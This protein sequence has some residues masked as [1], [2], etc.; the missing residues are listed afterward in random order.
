ME[1]DRR[2]VST[3]PL[4]QETWNSKLVASRFV[5]DA[6]FF[7]VKS[8]AIIL[9]PRTER[10]HNLT[11][12]PISFSVLRLSTESEFYPE[13]LDRFVNSCNIS[14]GFKF[15]RVTIVSYVVPWFSIFFFFVRSFTYP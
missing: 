14:S 4:R 8:V 2:F 9:L 15:S 12:N 7:S 10:L 13:L 11:P 3:Y 6:Y 1:S 5:I